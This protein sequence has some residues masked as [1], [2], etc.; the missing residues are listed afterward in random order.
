MAG[1]YIIN[2]RPP[3]TNLSSAEYLKK[4]N[5]NAN[6]RVQRDGLPPGLYGFIYNNGYH[7]PT[8]DERQRIQS[9]WIS[10]VGR[11]LH[12]LILTN[13]VINPRINNDNDN[14]YRRYALF[15][16]LSTNMMIHVKKRLFPQ[17]MSRIEPIDVDTLDTYVDALEIV[18]PKWEN[19]QEPASVESIL[20]EWIQKYNDAN[21]DDLLEYPISLLI[22][23]YD[24]IYNIADNT[25]G[26]G[27]V[28][29]D[30]GTINPR[31]APQLGGHYRKNTKKY[32]YK[33]TIS[34]N[35][36]HNGTKRTKTRSVRYNR[37]RYSRFKNK[38]GNYV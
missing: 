33:Q 26:G 28:F 4:R 35:R 5:F 3:G 12:P 18:R 20:Q 29:F 7:N 30:H 37:K 24:G 15:S 21:E 34:I 16:K 36:I 8:A 19:T 13:D 38:H 9:G 14:A 27:S 22:S 31:P 25:N 10:E 23:S 2:Y 11:L 32:K 6:T 1:V 17:A